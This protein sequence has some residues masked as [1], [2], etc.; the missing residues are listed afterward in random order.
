MKS[1]NDGDEKGKYKDE[2]ESCLKI[3]DLYSYDISVKGKHINR[4]I[5]K[6]QSNK[7]I[8]VEVKIKVESISEAEG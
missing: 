3:W 2:N 7:E 4:K 6:R 1:A 8:K 5:L